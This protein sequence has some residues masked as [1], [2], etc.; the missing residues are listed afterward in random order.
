MYGVVIVHE[1]LLE[2]L[3]PESIELAEPFRNKP[4][5]SIVGPLLRTTLNNHVAQFP[6][7][8][9]RQID[10]EQFVRALFEIDR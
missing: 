9:R 6:F 2:V 3:G 10:F 4:V 7:L 8:S 5:K 1:T